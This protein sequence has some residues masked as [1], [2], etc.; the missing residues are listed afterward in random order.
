MVVCAILQSNVAMAVQTASVD[1]PLTTIHLVLAL[2]HVGRFRRVQ[3][4]E[5][6][7][8]ATSVPY[9]TISATLYVSTTCLS[10]AVCVTGNERGRPDV[11]CGRRVR[12]VLLA[13]DGGLCSLGRIACR[14]HPTTSRRRQRWRP[15]PTRFRISCKV[16]AVGTA[17][18]CRLSQRNANSI[19]RMEQSTPFQVPQNNISVSL[20]QQSYVGEYN[21]SELNSISLQR[22]G[23]LLRDRL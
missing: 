14:G 12:L 2:R 9:T 22:I 13:R 20:H 1:V 21:V 6:A 11:G 5:T 16:F 15:R 17:L 19:E 10:A 4:T 23:H 18:R 8:T 3:A 7:V